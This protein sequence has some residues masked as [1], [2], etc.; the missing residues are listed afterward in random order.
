MALLTIASLHAQSMAAD[1][2]MA[3]VTAPC[4]IENFAIE[5]WREQRTVGVAVTL[6]V[7]SHWR[8]MTT[9]GTV[10]CTKMTSSVGIVSAKSSH[11]GFM[12]LLVWNFI[13]AQYG[14]QSD[15]RLPAFPEHLCW[16]QLTQ[17]MS[18]L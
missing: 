3:E 13:A 14:I 7:W 4:R 11:R 8:D 17:K 2:A 10:Y 1:Y 18:G 6:G 15:Q 9:V 12:R 5:K 16:P